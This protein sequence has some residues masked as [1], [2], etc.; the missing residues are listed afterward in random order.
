MELI[1]AA[2]NYDEFNWSINFGC[3]N[4]CSLNK[5]CGTF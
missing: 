4:S 1:Q 2:M 3:T 5:K